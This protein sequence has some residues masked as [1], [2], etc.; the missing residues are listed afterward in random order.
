M[1]ALKHFASIAQ[2]RHRGGTIVEA[3]L[4]LSVVI[5]IVMG[6]VQYG[7]AFYLKHALQQAAS[8]GARVA[9]MPGSTDTMV[10]TAV[11]NHLN[12]AGFGGL[13]ATIAT[14]PSSVNSVTPGT[15]V[16]V[17]VTASW[18]RVNINPLPTSMGGFSNSRTFTGSMTLLH[19]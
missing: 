15:Y 2:R 1:N 19:E 12:A 5:S 13:N 10:Q 16:T 7:Y 4:V 11:N 17:T 9:V 8:A 14:T 18:T 6:S 3:A